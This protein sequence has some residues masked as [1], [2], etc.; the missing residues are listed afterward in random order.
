MTWVLIILGSVFWI[1]ME[2]TAWLEMMSHYDE[3]V[4]KLSSL[5]SLLIF[6]ILAPLFFIIW[7][8][9]IEI[10]KRP[11]TKKEKVKFVKERISQ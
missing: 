4:I 7:R 8:S 3:R 5:F 10:C 9:D 6:I 11:L 1:W 2:Y